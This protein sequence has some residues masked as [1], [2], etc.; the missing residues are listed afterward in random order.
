[1]N[2]FIPPVL[3]AFSYTSL[4]KI[5]ISIPILP[6]GQLREDVIQVCIFHPCQGSQSALIH[7]SATIVSIKR[8]RFRCDCGEL[9]K[10]FDNA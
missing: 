6:S 10:C 4:L 5:L 1:M 8:I 7:P 9:V 2:L 3:S